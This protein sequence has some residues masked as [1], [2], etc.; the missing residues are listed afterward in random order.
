M[1]LLFCLHFRLW[2]ERTL[3]LFP[4]LLPLAPGDFFPG[5]VR[6]LAGAHQQHGVRPYEPP[7]P[8]AEAHLPPESPL[9]AV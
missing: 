3:S 4:R 8:E 5:G 7:V 6:A 2:T 1:F 9:V